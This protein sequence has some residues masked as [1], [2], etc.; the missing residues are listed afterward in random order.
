VGLFGQ[1]SKQSLEPI[2]VT[3]GNKIVLTHRSTA[4]GISHGLQ[5]RRGA[6][7]PSVQARLLQR[8]RNLEKSQGSQGIAHR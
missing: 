7:V 8:D 4:L 3:G 2:V 6:E 5:G 1:T